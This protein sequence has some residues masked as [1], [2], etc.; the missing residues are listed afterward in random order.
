MLSYILDSIKRKKKSSKRLDEY[1]QKQHLEL[2]V[3][4][5]E[6]MV[7]KD[8]PDIQSQHFPPNI[9]GSVLKHPQLNKIKNIMSHNSGVIAPGKWNIPNTIFDNL[10]SKK[11]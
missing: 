5:N 10:A 9:S 11:L 6:E 1:A 2:D 7:D 4:K 3:H 8:T